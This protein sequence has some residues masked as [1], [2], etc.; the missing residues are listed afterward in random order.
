MV[1]VYLGRCFRVFGDCVDAV[2]EVGEAIVSS[3]GSGKFTAMTPTELQPGAGEVLL[4]LR[5]NSDS[6]LSNPDICNV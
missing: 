5:H 4:A 1:H 3:T 6:P 2:H